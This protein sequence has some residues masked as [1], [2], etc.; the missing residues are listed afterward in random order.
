[1]EKWLANPDFSPSPGRDAY[2]S[3]RDRDCGETRR[4]SV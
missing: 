1:M 3:D 4:F 2:Y